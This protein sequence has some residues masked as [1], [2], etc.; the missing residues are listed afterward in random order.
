MRAG[1]AQKE[2]E[3]SD[4][5]CYGYGFVPC[6]LFCQHQTI[7]AR[8]FEIE[9]ID[10]NLDLQTSRRRYG[11]MVIALTE[12][13]RRYAA[14]ED[15]DIPSP[16]CCASGSLVINIRRLSQVPLGIDK[17]RSRLERHLNSGSKGEEKRYAYGSPRG[18]ELSRVLMLPSP[19]TAC[20]HHHLSF[21]LLLTSRFLC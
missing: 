13:S 14:V 15:R 12:S 7:N 18:R 10:L 1:H 5:L 6:F 17:L 19:T 16:M 9:S 3:D 11:A 2:T 20:H 8:H 4:C 21:C